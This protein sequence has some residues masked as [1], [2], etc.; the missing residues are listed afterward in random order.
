MLKQFSKLNLETCTDKYQIWADKFELLPMYFMNS[1][2]ATKFSDLLNAMSYAAYVYDVEHIVIDNLQFMIDLDDYWDR[3]RV[4]DRIVAGLRKFATDKNVHV[5]LV[6]HPRKER[7]DTMLDKSSVY[8]TAKAI[9]E[10]DNILIIHSIPG[11]AK[12]LEVSK[13]RFDGTQGQI[14][15]YYDPANCCFSI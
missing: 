3:F 12:F 6:V 13:N 9:Q 1:F 14:Q 4:Q 5:S 11:D 15:L 2:G 10:A 7:D 8:G